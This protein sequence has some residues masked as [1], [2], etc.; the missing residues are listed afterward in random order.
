MYY[1][2]EIHFTKYDRKNA[3]LDDTRAIYVNNKCI[4]V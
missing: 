4:I 3:Y 2:F 1:T